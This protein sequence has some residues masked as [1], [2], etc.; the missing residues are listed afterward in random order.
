MAPPYTHPVSQI[1]HPQF[2]SWTSDQALRAAD[3]PGTSLSNHRPSGRSTALL[4]DLTPVTCP[5]WA[6]SST[7]SKLLASEPLVVVEAVETSG[8][9][10]TKHVWWLEVFAQEKAALKS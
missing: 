7:E 2:F 3:H 5:L 6:Y 9:M 1:L 4:C 10:V 8:Q